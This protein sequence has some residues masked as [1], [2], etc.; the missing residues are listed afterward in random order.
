MGESTNAYLAARQ[1]SLDTGGDSRSIAVGL[2]INFDIK[3]YPFS[4]GGGDD[5]AAA[6]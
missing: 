5:Q 6:E 1:V 2:S 3:L 4:F